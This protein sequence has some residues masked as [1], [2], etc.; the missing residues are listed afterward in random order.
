MDD[1]KKKLIR[2]DPHKVQQKLFEM[3]PANSQV[4]KRVLSEAK[5]KEIAF[6]NQTIETVPVHIAEEGV[7][8]NWQLLT[9]AAIA[10]GFAALGS[11]ALVIYGVFF[12]KTFV[13]QLLALHLAGVYLFASITWIKESISLYQVSTAFT[14]SLNTLKKRLE[15]L[16]K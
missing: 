4:R 3:Y 9:S 2:I 13:E 12:N 1:E 7:K 5:E 10:G 11:I 16:K 14:D 6:L 8:R 15:D